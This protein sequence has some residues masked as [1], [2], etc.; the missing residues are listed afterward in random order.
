VDGKFNSSSSRDASTLLRLTSNSLLYKG[1][2]ENSIHYYRYYSTVLLR[3]SLESLDVPQE[4][5]FKA[6]SVES[7]C[8][9][10]GRL[11]LRE[12]QVLAKQSLLCK[13]CA[14]TLVLL[15]HR[16]CSL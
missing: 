3:R 15:S 11:E 1:M 7:V 10:P 2:N 5:T 6:S 12:R 9:W 16:C 4:S 14:S 13:N 8:P